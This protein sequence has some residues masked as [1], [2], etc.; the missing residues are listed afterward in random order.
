[1]ILES[2][3]LALKGLKENKRI[4]NTDVK[5]SY[6]SCNLWPAQVRT[7]YEDKYVKIAD[8][9]L[10]L[11]IPDIA[12][13]FITNGKQIFISKTSENYSIEEPIR[14]YLLGSA[15]GA[16][17]IQRGILLFHG[18]SLEK[19]GKA[20]ICLGDSGVG[21]STIAY[22]LMKNGWNLI[23]D[24]LVAL[25]SDGNVLPGIPRIKLWEDAVSHFG[26]NTNQLPRVAKGFNKFLITKESINCCNQKV[27]LDKF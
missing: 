9:Q 27:K 13:F 18:N 17:L 19:N 1:M 21:K 4:S 2:H 26:L 22:Q 23:S 7:N 11:N 24:D 10:T 25:D 20:I 12:K 14:T 6:K 16:L 3:G 5:I 15:I 8:N